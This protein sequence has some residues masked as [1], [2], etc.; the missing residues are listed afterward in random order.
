VAAIT[1]AR[2]ADGDDAYVPEVK[3]R[4]NV[5]LLLDDPGG[6][7]RDLQI[8]YEGRKAIFSYPRGNDPMGQPRVSQALGTATMLPFYNAEK[9]RAQR[10]KD[11]RLC[12]LRSFALK[13]MRSELAEC[14][15]LS[16]RVQ[17]NRSS[18]PGSAT[19]PLCSQRNA[20]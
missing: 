18:V 16:Y 19:S 14:H 15:R 9:R 5:I 3:R 13:V 2:I 20:L 10:K 8:H 12:A 6:G 17:Q 11:V 4:P 1:P 7:L